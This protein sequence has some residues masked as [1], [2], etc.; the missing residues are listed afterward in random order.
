VFLTESTSPYSKGTILARSIKDGCSLLLGP[1]IQRN[2]SFDLNEVFYLN[3][4]H[5]LWVTLPISL[6]KEFRLITVD[7]F[8]VFRLRSPDVTPRQWVIGFRSFEGTISLRNIGIRNP[9]DAMAHHEESPQIIFTEWPRK[10]TFL[11]VLMV[12]PD[13]NSL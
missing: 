7:V 8:A 1:E 13:W 9:S 10:R 12:K 4:S 5:L 11:S 2:Y 3:I 6:T